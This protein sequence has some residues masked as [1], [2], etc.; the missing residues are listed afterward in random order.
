MNV[1]FLK[2]GNIRA[3]SIF[4]PPNGQQDRQGH[5]SRVKEYPTYSIPNIRNSNRTTTQVNTAQAKT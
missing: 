5:A 2:I 4:L 1:I 3:G